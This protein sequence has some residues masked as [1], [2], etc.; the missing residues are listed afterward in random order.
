MQHLRLSVLNNR[1]V[2]DPY[3][4]DTSSHPPELARAHVIARALKLLGHE[5]DAEAL[6]EDFDALMAMGPSEDAEVLAEFEAAFDGGLI[7]RLVQEVA[8]ACS[9]LKLVPF[10]RA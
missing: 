6:L 1:T 10:A 3:P 7:E 2:R 8:N 5:S 4:P 9:R